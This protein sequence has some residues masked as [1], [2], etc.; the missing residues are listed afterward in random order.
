MGQTA[1]QP[2]LH[3]VSTAAAHDDDRPSLDKHDAADIREVQ[4]N[5]HFY[6]TVTAAPLNPWSRTSFQLYLILL[7]AALNATAS[8]FDGSIFSSINAMPQY[9]K[10]FHHTELGSATGMQVV[11]IFQQF[12]AC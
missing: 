12:M 7:V 5:A 2:E 1:D 9:Q 4:G 8:G 11:S 10:Y 3:H 6:E